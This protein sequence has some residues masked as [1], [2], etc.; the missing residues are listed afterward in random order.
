[1]LASFLFQEPTPEQ[2]GSNYGG[3]ERVHPL[4]LAALGILM[5]LMLVLPRRFAGLPIVLLLCFI[6]TGQRIVLITLDFTF[7][8][9]LLMAAWIRMFI[10]REI[11]PLVWNSLDRTMVVWAIVSV[12]FGT[13]QLA[14]LTGFINRA[15]MTGDAMMTYFFFRMTIRKK[16]DLAAIALQFILS[17]MAV[18][19]FFLFENRTQTNMFHIFGGVE[20]FT[21]IRDGRLRC[22]GAFAHPILAGCFWACCLPFYF[23]RGQLGK[24]WFLTVVGAIAAGAIIV[25][26]ASSTPIMAVVF[27]LCAVGAWFIRGSLRW[28]RWLILLW[29]MV[30][31]FFMMKQPVWHLLARIDIAGGSTGWH[32]YHL[33]DEAINHFYEW[34]A[35][36]TPRTGHWG[37]GLQDVT[38]QYV[39]E[40]IQG[41]VW[42]LIVFAMAV[43]YAFAGVSRSMRMPGLPRADRLVAWGLGTAVF[44]HCM[45]FIGV[46]YFEQIYTLW[47]LTLAA[48]GSLTL[49]PGA[50]AV[51]QVS[52]ISPYALQRA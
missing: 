6:P 37:I 24:G 21:E 46:S 12:L 22:Q 2:A 5:L 13:L 29:L 1:M 20:R 44:M 35:V 17:G 7:I 45:N 36:G 19:W 31:H 18:V 52:L 27:G 9:L 25:L 47:Y 28:V 48:I 43:W 30:L 34:W 38:N 23:L 32:R 51:Q 4:G 26:C 15:G 8:R 40:A 41:G 14:T 42:R 39:A 3:T 11:V 49:V 10:R 50:S 16:E 33:V